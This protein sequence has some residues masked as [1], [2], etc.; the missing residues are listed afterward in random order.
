M[1]EIPSKI[2][3]L[4][5]IARVKGDVISR[6]IPKFKIFTLALLACSSPNFVRGAL[7]II[8]SILPLKAAL[9]SD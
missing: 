6:L 1:G 4:V 2:I 7:K 3:F 8:G 9:N 5:W